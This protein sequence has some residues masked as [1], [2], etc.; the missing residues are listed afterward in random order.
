VF[1]R[2]A[3]VVTGIDVG[4]SSVKAVRLS[5]NGRKTALLGAAV[6]ELGGAED[7][8]T[9]AREQLDA[10]L[11]E[12]VRRVLGEVGHSAQDTVVASVG[13]SNVSVKHVVFPKMTKQALAESIHWEARKHVPFGDSDFVLDFQILSGGNGE[14]GQMSVLL[15]AVESKAVDRLLKVLAKAG[16]EPDTIDIAPLALMNEA[17]EEGLIDGETV[18]LVEIGATHLVLAVYR[19][20]GLF[21]TRS[22]PLGRTTHGATGRR[23]TVPTDASWVDGVLSE[24]RRSLNY[25]N[26]ETGKKGIERIYLAGGRA[27]DESV[28]KA[29]QEKTGVAT[30]V[31]N[32]LEKVETSAVDL[33]DLTSQGPRLAVVMGL[34]RRM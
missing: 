32:P 18:A 6:A 3:K 5:H 12:T 28:R 23:T 1:G 21:F 31:L 10:Q 4:T 14:G 7:G 19:R 27:L 16:V 25:Y 2:N 30:N 20:G 8:T 29:F 17:D 26:N 22:V 33:G 24:V 34:A 13:G 11:T 9:P 15:A